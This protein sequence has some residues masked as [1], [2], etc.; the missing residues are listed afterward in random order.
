MGH[1]PDSVQSD[2]SS[3]KSKDKDPAKL[4]PAQNA[5]SGATAG[6]IS[7]FVIAPLDVVKIRYKYIIL[8]KTYN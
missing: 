1:G 4:T 8:L 5:I 6:V 2:S 7:R 3:S